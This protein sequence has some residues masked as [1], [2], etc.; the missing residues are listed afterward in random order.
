MKPLT[1][2]AGQLWVHMF[3]WKME[4]CCPVLQILSLTKILFPTPIVFRSMVWSPS[5]TST[6]G[7]INAMYMFR[8]KSCHHRIEY[9]TLDDIFRLLFTYR[10]VTS[11]PFLI[12]QGLENGI[13]ASIRLLLS[14]TPI[15]FLKKGE[16]WIHYS[17]YQASTSSVTEKWCGQEMW[18]NLKGFGKFHPE[19]E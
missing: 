13:V 12:S 11:H 19:N 4:M 6:T 10:W 14:L 9:I 2:G 15:L 8:C 1:L 3:P 7:V 18:R 5:L 17:A 16:P